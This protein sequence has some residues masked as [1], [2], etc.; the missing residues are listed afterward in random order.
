MLAFLF[1]LIAKPG[2]CHKL[3]YHTDT[4]LYLLEVRG[5]MPHHQK[6]L[7]TSEVQ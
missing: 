3:Y 7:T 4:W 5:L 2:F 6:W 1:A